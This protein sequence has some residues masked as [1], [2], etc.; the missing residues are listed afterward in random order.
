MKR[1]PAALRACSPTDATP[2]AA[3][4]S[5]LLHQ[6]SYI[7]SFITQHPNLKQG[8]HFHDPNDYT[9]WFNFTPPMGIE[10]PRAEAAAK[11]WEEDAFFAYQY[12]NGIHPIVA[13]LVRNR[14][15]LMHGS[16]GHARMGEAQ[17]A[18]VQAYLDSQDAG[19]T[20]DALI[21]ARRLLVADYTRLAGFPLRPGTYLYPA[22]LLLYVPTKPGRSRPLM[23]L[24]VQLQGG[25]NGELVLPDEGNAWLFAKMHVAQ[26]DATIHESISHLGNTHL[27]L[28]GIIVAVNRHLPRTHPI[29]MMLEPHFQQTLALTQFAMDSLI[30]PVDYRYSSFT[31]LGL[32]GQQPAGVVESMSVG[33]IGIMKLIEDNH[34]HEFDLMESWPEAMARKGWPAPGVDGTLRARIAVPWLPGCTRCAVGLCCVQGLTPTWLSLGLQAAPMWTTPST[35]MICTRCGRAWR[36]TSSAW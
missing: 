13:E 12:L 32:V 18:R 34:L 8:V 19:D 10:F 3:C 29:Y 36:S 15:E 24:A 27:A 31:P 23:P 26:A 6:V 21:D 33:L 22:V 30:K 25:D 35:E 7:N 4:W 28:S 9:S 11:H 20:L 16:D 5:W 2:R 14:T 17:L 1:R